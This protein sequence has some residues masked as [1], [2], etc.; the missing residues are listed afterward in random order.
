MG[1]F[2]HGFDMAHRSRDKDVENS[3]SLAAQNKN[4]IKRKCRFK[5]EKKKKAEREG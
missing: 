2:V 4:P 3:Q 5:L 1:K